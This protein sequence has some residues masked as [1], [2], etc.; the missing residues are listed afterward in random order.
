[1]TPRTVFSIC[2][3]TISTSRLVKAFR[4]AL[5]FQRGRPT[6]V[7]GRPTPLAQAQGTRHSHNPGGMCISKPC[8]YRVAPPAMNAGPQRVKAPL[9]H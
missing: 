3:E 1:M 8:R 5:H 6:A 9:G 2:L 4:P 7:L